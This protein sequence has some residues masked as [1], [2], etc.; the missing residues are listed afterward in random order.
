MDRQDTQKGKAERRGSYDYDSKQA[1]RIQHYKEV[2]KLKRIYIAAILLLLCTLICSFEFIFV[3]RRA[4]DYIDKIN[5]IEKEYRDS[6]NSTALSLADSIDTEWSRTVSPMDSLLYHDY[7]DRISNNISKLS[8]LILENDS[9]TFYTTCTEIKNQ[10]M[11]LKKS[12]VPNFE[13]II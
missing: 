6:N 10:L 9:S 4:E 8:I 2:R 11:S 5:R 13:N 7:V 12:E 1:K 3:S